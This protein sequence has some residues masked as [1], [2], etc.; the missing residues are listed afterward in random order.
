MLAPF[1]ESEAAEE[2]VVRLGQE[3]AGW[4]QRHNVNVER[5]GSLVLALSRDGGELDRFAR[6]TDQHEWVDAGD[7]AALEAAL[8]GRAQR[9]RFLPNAAH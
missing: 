1:C 8:G 5:N 9:G 6:R 4:W 2:P 7:V 3:A